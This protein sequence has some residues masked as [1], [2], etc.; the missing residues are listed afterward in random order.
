VQ[1]YH[2]WNVYPPIGSDSFP[3]INFPHLCESFGFIH[4]VKSLE[5]LPDTSAPANTV[6]NF[7]RRTIEGEWGTGWPEARSPVQSF[8]LDIFMLTFI[9]LSIAG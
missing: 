4:T 7:L 8:S 3:E 9:S 2:E 6:T 5:L 1:I